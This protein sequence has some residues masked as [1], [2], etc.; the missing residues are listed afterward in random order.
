MDILGIGLRRLLGAAREQNMP[1]VLLWAALV[2]VGLARR[3][4]T[5]GD[6]LVYSKKMK[7]GESIRVAVAR[8][9]A[10]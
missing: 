5:G 2:A 3:M 4:S 1:R 9:D 10:S 8:A 6:T 7:P